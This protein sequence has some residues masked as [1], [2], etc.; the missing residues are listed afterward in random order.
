MDGNG[1]WAKDR[2]MPRFMGHRQGAK[3]VREI[4]EAAAERGLECLSLFAFSEENWLRP[5]TEVKLLMGLFDKYLIKEKP[6]LAKENIRLV[7]TGDPSRLSKKTREIIKECT[8]HLSHNTGMTLNLCVSYSGKDEI[9]EAAKKL[10]KLAHANGDPELKQVQ[11]KDFESLLSTEQFGPVDLMIRTSG[12]K[13]ISNFMIWQLAYAEF[14]FTNT[15]WP[16]FQ[17][18][19]FDDALKWYQGRERRFGK[20]DNAIQSPTKWDESEWNKNAED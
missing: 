13:R 17:K 8:E 6:L 9:F 18:S 7:V 12:E 19:D 2:L 5:P 10:A 3:G 20:V 11:M 4:V 16:D 14:Y 1:R 15:Y